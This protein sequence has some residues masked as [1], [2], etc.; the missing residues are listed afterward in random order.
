M[1]ILQDLRYG[2]RV[3]AKKPGFT[4]V[5]VFTL[6]L[7]IGANSAIFSVVNGLLLSPLP[8]RDS[9]RL[10]VIW[11]HSPGANVDQDWPSP[12]QYSAIKSQNTVFEEIAIALGGNVNLTGQSAP[13]RV[14]AVWAS[15]VLFSLLDVTPVFGRV[16]LAE[17]DSPG[18]PP[19]AILSYGLWQRRFGG[20]SNVIGQGLTADGDNYTIVGVLP[21]DFSLNQEMMPTV[22]AAAQ[23][24]VFLSLPLSANDLSSQGDENYNV[25]ALL[26]PGVKIP[27]AQAELDSI[28]RELERQFPTQYPASRRFSL[29]VRPLLEQVVGDIRPALLVLLG[30]VACVLLIACANVA[31]LLLARAASREKEIAIRTA[32]GAGRWRLVRQLLTESVLLSVAGGALGLLIAIWGLDG[33]RWLDPGN[34]PRLQNV[35]IDGRVLGFTFGVAMLTGML[36]GLAPALRGSQVDLSETLKEGGRSLAGSGNHRLRNLLVIAEMALSLV[37]LIGAGLLIRSFI[38]VQQVEPGFATQNLLSLRLGVIGTTYAKEPRRASFYQQLWERVRQLPGVESAGGVSALPLSGGIGWG[39]ITIDGYDAASGQSSI[40][41]DARVA[42]VGYFETMKIPLISGRFFGEQ[43]G[44]DSMKV[45]IIDENMARTY[46]PGRDAVGGRF[47]RG[48]TDSTAPW[49]T[50][51]GVVAN[52]KHYAL[53]LNSRVAFYMPQRQSGSTYMY[54][55]IRTVGDP[56]SVAAAV[57]QE[58]RAMDPN[59]PVYDVKTMDQRLSESLARRR[60]AMFALG[61]FAAVAALLAAVGIY[62]VMSYT[63]AQ[64]AREIGI[65][66]ALGA[67]TGDV[68]RLVVGQGMSLA[69]IGVGAGLAAA[70]VITRVMSSLLFGVSAT[71]PATFAAIA[72]LLGSVALLACYVPARRAMK[73]DPMVALRY[74]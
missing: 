25:M 52:V 14:G 13:E 32:I 41:A 26:K 8:Y 31:N 69:V 16:F 24:E 15:S 18:K 1:G 46:W 63:V 28:V 10:A 49:M 73:V 53:D 67:Q 55:A 68:L 12:G 44:K 19:A 6:A 51:I 54:V 37:L 20:D 71:D 9:D 72:L 62:G 2:S 56:L 3:L 11:T 60:F 7:G 35:R 59:A 39:S 61:L 4:L 58:A 48:G 47:K 57:T 29:S 30:A 34:I 27:Q 65:R 66:V 40:Q 70:A 33:L 21:P 64:R 45:A 36:F 23:A 5:A 38:R 17:E 50:V 74:E 42:T 43:D 22:G